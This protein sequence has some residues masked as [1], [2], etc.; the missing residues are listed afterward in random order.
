MPVDFPLPAPFRRH[1]WRLKIYDKE[2]LEPPHVTLLYRTRRWRVSLRT[3]RFLD[4][5]PAPREVPQ[6][7]VD[8]IVRNLDAYCS[9]WNE[10]YPHNP[11]G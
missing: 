4:R 11:C 10:M 6:A 5:R 7:L 3:G 8:H 2:R 9:E 1:G